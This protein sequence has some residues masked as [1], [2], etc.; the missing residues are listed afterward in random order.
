MP[1]ELLTKVR[2]CYEQIWGLRSIK[3]KSKLISKTITGPTTHPPFIPKNT[4]T[5]YVLNY[6]IIILKP[7]FPNKYSTLKLQHFKRLSLYFFG[8]ST[9]SNPGSHTNCPIYSSL[10]H[11][12]WSSLLKKSRTMLRVYND[13][14][15]FVIK[16]KWHFFLQFF[17][18]C[19][20]SVCYVGSYNDELIFYSRGILLTTK[21]K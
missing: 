2:K 1:Q 16:L 10:S 7:L 4:F 17:F 20:R 19:P 15:L 3:P 11:I 12:P 21:Y 9:G 18:S 8:N 5:Y 13:H 14:F 6:T